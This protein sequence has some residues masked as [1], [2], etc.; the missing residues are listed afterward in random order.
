MKKTIFTAQMAFVLLATPAFAGN[1][2]NFTYLALGDSIPFGMN[3][4]L[5][6]SPPTP[7]PSEFVGYPETVAAAEH[8]LISKKLA[9]ASC[10]GESSGSFLDVNTIQRDYGCNFPH[11]LPG[12]GSIPPFKQLVGLKVDYTGAQMDYAVAE[13]ASNKHID[14]V[15]LSIG[16]NDVFVCLSDPTCSLQSVLD[17]VN[18]TYK[19]NLTTILTNIRKYYTGKLVL[20]KYYSPDPSL[21]TLAMAVNAVMTQVGSAFDVRF[22]DGFTAFKTASAMFGGDACQAGLLIRLPPGFPT[23][24]DIHPSP[25]GRDLLAAIVEIALQQ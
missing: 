23:P 13:L 6:L 17:P 20:L 8:L 16:A 3:I 25:A 10:P 12:G 24:C 7:T 5:V 4:L 11:P 14:M 9:N 22:A 19:N 2:K 18:G 1:D 21:D 15:T